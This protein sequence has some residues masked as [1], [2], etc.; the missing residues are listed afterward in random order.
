[1]S[2]YE[3][4]RGH[5]NVEL[6]STF[7]ENLLKWMRKPLVNTIIEIL[8]EFVL[9]DII[10]K[11]VIPVQT[12]AKDKSIDFSYSVDKSIRMVIGNPFT[13]EELYSNLLS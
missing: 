2:A 5:D 10:N 3:F 4:S 11:L 6:L 1:M 7:I 9:E 13:I 8:E 12:L